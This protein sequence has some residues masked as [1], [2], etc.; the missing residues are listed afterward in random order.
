MNRL[1]LISRVFSPALVAL[2]VVA[3]AVPSAALA[4]RGRGGARQRAGAATSNRQPE[5]ARMLREIDA[6]NIERSIRKLVSFGTRNTLSAQ[7][8]PARGIGAARDWL[9]DEFERASRESGGRLKVELQGFEQQP[10]RFP[11]IHE[12]RRA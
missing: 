3:L 7:D 4:Q 8:N 9:R 6:R 12:S 10:G 5:I 11:R 2:F 1:A